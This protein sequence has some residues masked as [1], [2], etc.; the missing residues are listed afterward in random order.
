MH[1]P[2]VYICRVCRIIGDAMQQD[3]VPVPSGVD[4]SQGLLY[5]AKERHPCR[6]DQRFALASD[7]FQ[8]G[9]VGY[10]T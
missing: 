2:K 10:F 7:L 9:M 3:Y 8:K 1:S 4:D 6:E 5:F